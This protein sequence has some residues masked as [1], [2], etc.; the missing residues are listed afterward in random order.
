MTLTLL[1]DKLLIRATLKQKELM[2]PGTR[3][4]NGI[5]Q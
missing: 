1:A 2:S 4:D 5:G 3:S